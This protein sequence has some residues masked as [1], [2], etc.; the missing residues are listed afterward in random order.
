[1]RND[2]TV[3]GGS[4]ALA[5]VADVE[6]SESEMHELVFHNCQNCVA[7]TSL[8]LGNALARL[9]KAAIFFT[10]LLPNRVSWWKIKRGGLVMKQDPVRRLASRLQ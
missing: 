2:Y 5:E 8:C 1:M 3:F 7:A 6:G 10:L 9:N 4:H